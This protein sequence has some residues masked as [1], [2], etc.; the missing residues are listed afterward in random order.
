MS[1]ND[2]IR[3]NCVP[4]KISV[5]NSESSDTIFGAPTKTDF[6]CIFSPTRTLLTEKNINLYLRNE[7]VFL[8]RMVYMSLNS[9]LNLTLKLF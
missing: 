9:Y 1:L 6:L 4:I 2:V 8:R 5:K 7:Q 3:V